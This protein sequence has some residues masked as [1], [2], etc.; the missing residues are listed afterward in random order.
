MQGGPSQVHFLH[1]CHLPQL[2]LQVQGSKHTSRHSSRHL[3]RLPGTQYC[4]VTHS[5]HLR[6]RILVEHTCL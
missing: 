1:L 4:S 5:W 3:M 2:V 6:V